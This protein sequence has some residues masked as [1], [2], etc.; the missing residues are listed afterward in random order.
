[1][2]TILSSYLLRQRNNIK[3]H[4]TRSRK[5]SAG[6]SIK[7][8][9]D[10]SPSSVLRN[11]NEDSFLGGAIVEGLYS[12]GLVYVGSLVASV[13]AIIEEPVKGSGCKLNVS[14]HS[15]RVKRTR[16]LPSIGLSSPFQQKSA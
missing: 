3:R 7:A 14:F 13:S 16:T 4:N 2:V 15:A 8:T 1:M 11:P 6:T 9:L 12:V 10:D 5:Q